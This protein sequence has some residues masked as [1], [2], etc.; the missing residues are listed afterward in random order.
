MS[1]KITMSSLRE[2][3]QSLANKTPALKD[4]FV[5]RND[6][7]IDNCLQF[8]VDIRITVFT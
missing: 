8:M 5:P 6:E 4:C 3:K 7:Q 2:T 1:S